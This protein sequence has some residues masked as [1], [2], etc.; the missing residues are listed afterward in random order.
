MKEGENMYDLHVHSYYSDGKLSPKKIAEEAA[1]IG[2]KGI[3]LSDHDS[4]DG[5]EKMQYYGK[6]HGIEVM[7]AVEFG[8]SWVFEDQMV[9]IHILGYDMDPTCQDLQII[10]KKLVDAR[11]D[12][13]VQM[14]NILRDFGLDID[15]DEVFAQKKRGLIGRGQ[16]ADVLVQKRYVSNVGDAFERFIGS[17]KFAYVPKTIYTYHEII[18]LIHHCGGVAVCAHPKTLRND[19]ILD[20]LIAAGLDGIEVINSK[21]NVEDVNRYMTKVHDNERLIATAGSDCHGHRNE[22]GRMYLGRYTCSENTKFNLIKRR[23]EIRQRR[24]K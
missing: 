18:D 9:E 1:R 12:R 3:A 8:T 23:N 17:G 21:H 22:N 10:L 20:D 2:L 6:K 16:I 15:A 11:T 14:V 5:V 7:P 19:A 4:M 24:G 13:V